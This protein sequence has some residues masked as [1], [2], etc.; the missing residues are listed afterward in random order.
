MRNANIVLN[1]GQAANVATRCRQLRGTE[2]RTVTV[3]AVK[4]DG[5]DTTLTGTVLE[6]DTRAGGHGFVKVDTERG[7]RTANLHLIKRVTF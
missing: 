4:R 5:T 2:G 6:V 7:P 3:E 1:Q